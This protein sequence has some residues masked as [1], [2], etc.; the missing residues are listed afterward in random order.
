V[1]KN[2]TPGS[3]QGAINPHRGVYLC[4]VTW[5]V[6]SSMLMC[7]ITALYVRENCC[8]WCGVS[9]RELRRMQVF[10]A[11]MATGHYNA[12][13]NIILIKLIVSIMRLA[14]VAHRKSRCNRELRWIKYTWY[15]WIRA[16]HKM[17]TVHWRDGREQCDAMETFFS[18]FERSNSFFSAARQLTVNLN[19]N[20]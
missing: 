6:Q 14:V 16:Q 12:H 3:S 1:C 9:V 19:V 17:H 11:L 13:V 8:S 2:L 15:K 5:R 10:H 7:L 20:Y 18:P 4:R